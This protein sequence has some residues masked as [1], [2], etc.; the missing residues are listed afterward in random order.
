M[1]NIAIVLFIVSS[2]LIGG[3]TGKISGTALDGSTKEPLLGATIQIVGTS[4]GAASGVDGSLIILNASPGTYSVRISSLGY[5][6][7]L[8]EQVK[9]V[10]DQTTT[11][12]VSLKPTN[13]ELSEVIVSAQTPAI[14]KDLTSSL[15]VINSNDIK[16]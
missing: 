14:Q 5:E 6:A 13:V 15:S 3:T 16:V 9:I 12:S 11:L 7:K 1:K 2:F 4:L 10:A 8:I